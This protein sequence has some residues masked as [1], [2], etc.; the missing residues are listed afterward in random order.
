MRSNPITANALPDASDHTETLPLAC[1]HTQ[2]G[3][4]VRAA[5]RAARSATGYA[6]LTS[7]WKAP[8]RI[9]SP[10]MTTT[11]TFGLSSMLIPL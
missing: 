8:R 10:G 2:T 1:A 4:K 7:A 9:E 3:G 11:L 6:M 5:P